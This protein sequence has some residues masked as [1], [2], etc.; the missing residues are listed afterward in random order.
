MTAHASDGLLESAASLG[1]AGAVLPKPLVIE[2]RLARI[3]GPGGAQQQLVED[4][5]AIAEALGINLRARGYGRHRQVRQRR[6]APPGPGRGS[7]SSPSRSR[8]RPGP[9]R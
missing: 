4:D 8:R 6:A 3:L 1:I 7:S 9:G 5:E 2:D